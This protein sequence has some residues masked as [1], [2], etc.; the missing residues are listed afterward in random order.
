MIGAKGVG[1]SW[2]VTLPAG[3]RERKDGNNFLVFCCADLKKG[4]IVGCVELE[5]PLQSSMQRGNATLPMSWPIVL[6]L[7]HG[8]MAA[9]IWYT[10]LQELLQVLALPFGCEIEVKSLECTKGSVSAIVFQSE[11][12]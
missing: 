7:C 11:K 9:P 2:T 10:G 6:G 5:S 3:L 4:F 1:H 8:S 12:I